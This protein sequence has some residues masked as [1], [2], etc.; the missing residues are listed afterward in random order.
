[1]RNVN[2]ATIRWVAILVLAASFG[3]GG[4][5]PAA[6]EQLDKNVDLK[7]TVW[8]GRDSEGDD[9]V[10]SF[11]PDGTVAYKSPTG[12]FRNGKWS[13]FGNAVYFHMNDH[14]SEY[15]GEVSGRSLAGKAW[16]VTGRKWTWRT[17]RTK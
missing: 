10:F 13:Q 12:S 15:L 11:E 4:D 3:G 1:M 5:T 2:Q 7:G 16:N 8:S 6:A 14:Y 9:Y 17:T